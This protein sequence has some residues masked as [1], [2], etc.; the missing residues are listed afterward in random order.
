VDE[1]LPGTPA[2]HEFH[3]IGYA[4][5]SIER[6]LATFSQLG[7]RSEGHAFTDPIQ[8][9]RGL[10]LVGAGPRIE[11]LENLP[12]SATLTPWLASGIRL[13]HI[14]YTV[15]DTAAAVAWARAQRARITVEPVPAVAFHGRRISFAMF[16]NGLLV[17][18]IER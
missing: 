1:A 11:L 6:E 12:G 18:F 10:F 13:Y 9:I 17:E 4:T 8:G 7:Y 2:G 15:P 14:A 3:H 5:T 16:R